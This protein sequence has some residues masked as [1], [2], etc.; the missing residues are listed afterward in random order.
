MA[1]TIAVV[2]MCVFNT[3]AFHRQGP[4]TEIVTGYIRRFLLS[5]NQP[6]GAGFPR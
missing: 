5:A 6:I 4:E 1:G 2:E 3:I